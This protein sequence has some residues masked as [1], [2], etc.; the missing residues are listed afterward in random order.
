MGV[1]DNGKPDRRTIKRKSESG[2]LQLID[3]HG[4]IN[5]DSPAQPTSHPGVMI[6]MLIKTV[7]SKH[8]PWLLKHRLTG[9]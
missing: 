3:D 1:R 6:H 5:D 9:K 7:C 8:T 4:Q 2:G